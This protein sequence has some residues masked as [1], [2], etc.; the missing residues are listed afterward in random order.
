[1][2]TKPSECLKRLIKFLSEKGS[3]LEDFQSFGENVYLF[4]INYMLIKIL[5][6]RGLWSFEISRKF[7]RENKFYEFSYIISYFEGTPPGSEITIDEKADYFVANYDKIT[8]LFSRENYKGTIEML[9]AKRLEY[10]KEQPCYNAWFIND[11]SSSTL[12]NKNSN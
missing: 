3:T 7:I 11:K 10:L 6:D 5:S 4:E 9:E 12:D 2:S 8:K 1:M